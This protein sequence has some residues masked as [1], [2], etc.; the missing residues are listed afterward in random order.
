MTRI[1]NKYLIVVLAILF[2]CVSFFQYYSIIS[3]IEEMFQYTT[4][5]VRNEVLNSELSQFEFYWTEIFISLLL[6][7]L[8]MFLCLNIGFLYFNIKVKIR[9]VIKLI[10]ISF[11]AVIFNQFLA[12]LII[13]L[14]NWTFT[15]GSMNS[16]FE[17]LNLANYLKV[18]EIAPW[19]KLSLESIN[20]GQLL[21]IA[22]LIIGMQK[23]LKLNYKKAFS[24]TTKTYGLGVFLWFVFA[25]VMEMNFS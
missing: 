17:K 23:V 5:E 2:I 19:V 6:Q 12:I 14:N 18:D 13:I 11:L 1:K 22:L 16:V 24:V 4:N 21:T 7:S 10:L 3:Y 15:V 8:G 20:L 25:M 9:D